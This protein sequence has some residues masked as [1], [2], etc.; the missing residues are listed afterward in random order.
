[1]K[2]IIRLEEMAM[3]VAS[4]LALIY[5][6]VPYWYY[7]ILFLGPDISMFGYLL[8]NKTGAACYNIFHHKG[9]AVTLLAAGFF[10]DNWLL[11]VTGL[12][13]LGHSSM[14]R[15]MGYGLKYTEG[16]KF[17]HLGVIGK[18]KA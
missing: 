6:K 12:I 13:L 9:I 8:G 4:V 5:L 16:F 7:M 18:N 10:Y 17:T 14:D 2:N 3:L 1:M 15:M 11:Q